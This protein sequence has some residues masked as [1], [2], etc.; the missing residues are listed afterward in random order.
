M[1]R[2]DDRIAIVTGAGRGIGGAVATQLA[3]E[4]AR[5]V[6]NDNGAELDGSGHDEGPANGRG[7]PRR[8]WGGRAQLRRRRR[9]QRRRIHRQNGPRHLRGPGRAG[10]RTLINQQPW[11]LDD[12][13]Q[14]FETEIRRAVE[15]RP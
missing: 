13:W 15:G 7:N 9:F 3:A 11:Q 1:G 2:L 8:R 4:G 5:V 12:V 6:V 10:Q 14:G